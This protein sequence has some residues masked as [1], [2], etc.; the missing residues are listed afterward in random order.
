[1][2]FYKGNCRECDSPG[3][4]M[5]KGDGKCNRCGGS[6]ID[7]IWD[8]IPSAVTTGGVRNCERCGGTGV[9]PRCDG[10]GEHD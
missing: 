8:A 10:K 2:S 6:G 7:N 9:C 5:V 3:D 1:M 4:N